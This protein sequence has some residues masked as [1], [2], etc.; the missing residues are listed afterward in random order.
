M[1]SVT[2]FI[3]F[4]TLIGLANVA[5]D[6]FIRNFAPMKIAQKIVSVF[7]AVVFLASSLGFTVNKMT[8]LKSGKVVLSAT[9]A[10]ECCNDKPSSKTTIKKR[11]CDLLNSSFC[12]SDFQNTEK[13][14]IEKSGASYLPLAFLNS[15]DNRVIFSRVASQYFYADL[16]PPLH[17]RQLLT[18]ISTL[19][20]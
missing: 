6:I 1:I 20:I 17:G 15:S 2:Y 8:C 3:W 9:A 7:L 16:P 19:I 5:D 18:F 13:T 11:C 4:F 10:K 14:T 12:L